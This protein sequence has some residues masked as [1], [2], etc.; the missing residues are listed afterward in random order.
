MDSLDSLT[1]YLIS[2]TETKEVKIEISR[3]YV[4]I[5]HAFLMCK[6]YNE[7]VIHSKIVLKTHG[8]LEK[9][10]SELSKNDHRRN[11]NLATVMPEVAEFIQYQKG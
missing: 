10:I 5:L 3:E 6:K 7:Y 1:L 4:Q 2:K 8:V 11:S 9:V